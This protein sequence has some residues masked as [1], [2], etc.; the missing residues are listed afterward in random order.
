MFLIYCDI[1]SELSE[2]GKSLLWNNRTHHLEAG[3]VLRGSKMAQRKPW[4]E[5]GQSP[6]FG[7]FLEFSLNAVV[8]Q[9]WNKSKLSGQ[10]PL[11]WYFGYLCIQSPEFSK[12]KGS[13]G[14]LKWNESRLVMSDFLQPHGL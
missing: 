5:Q 9:E 4:R 2:A 10:S 7:H 1:D 11:F 8:S 12:V 13:M 3:A 14:P 6:A